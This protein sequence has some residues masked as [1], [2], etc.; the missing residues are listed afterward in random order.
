VPALQTRE[1]AILLWLGVVSTGVT[2]LLFSHALR[3]VSA[4]TAVVLALAEPVTAFLLAGLWVEVRSE[5]RTSTLGK[6]PQVV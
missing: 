3:H 2:Y 5:M 1:A 6:R 4:A